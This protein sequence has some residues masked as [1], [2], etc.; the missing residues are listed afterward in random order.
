[1]SPTSTPN[2]AS[3]NGHRRLSRYFRYCECLIIC[4]QIQVNQIFKLH[5]LLDVHFIYFLDYLGLI[6]VILVLQSMVLFVILMVICS[7]YI[8]R[9]FTASSQV[10]LAKYLCITIW[11]ASDIYVSY[12]CSF[13]SCITDLRNIYCQSLTDSSLCLCCQ[14]STDWFKGFHVS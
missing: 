10:I 11:L 6:S 5:F 12:V 7:C 8:L 4:D 13:L 3:R 14:Y 9:S 2:K 1:M